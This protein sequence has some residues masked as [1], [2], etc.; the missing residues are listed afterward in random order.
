M[1][2]RGDRLVARGEERTFGVGGGGGAR[3]GSERINSQVAMLLNHRV[4]PLTGLTTATHHRELREQCI[5]A[6]SFKLHLMHRDERALKP[7][8]AFSRQTLEP[9]A[10]LRVFDHLPITQRLILLRLFSFSKPPRP[11]SLAQRDFGLVDL[12][13]CSCAHFVRLVFPKSPTRL[14][15]LLCLRLSLFLR[16]KWICAAP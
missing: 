3:A 1:L 13:P 10:V 15:Q 14:H 6:L 11:A 5:T 7:Q 2:G 9:F 12:V 16:K 4:S 8:A